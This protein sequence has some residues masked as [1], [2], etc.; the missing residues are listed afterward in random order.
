MLR[1]VSIVIMLA[2]VVVPP[3]VG[4]RKPQPTPTPYSPVGLTPMPST[5]IYPPPGGISTVTEEWVCSMHP[6][7]K[8]PQPG[9]CSICGMDLV[10][11]SELSGPQESSSGSGHSQHSSGSGNSHSSGSGCGSC[12]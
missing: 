12:G 3:A 5:D 9:R 1:T 2:L 11:A 10:P 6:T 7:F 8:M 4:C